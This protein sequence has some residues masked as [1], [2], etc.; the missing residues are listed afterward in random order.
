MLKKENR[1]KNKLAFKAT[2]NNGCVIVSKQIIAYFGKIKNNENR[3]TRVGFVVSKKVHKRA[4]KRNKLKRLMRETIRLIIKNN[5]NPQINQ[6]KS[7]IFVARQNALE[8]NFNEIQEEIV[9]L[10]NK[11]TN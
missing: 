1:L 6:F 10:I 4:T 2:Y 9:T 7:I 3:P 8:K 11:L 5:S